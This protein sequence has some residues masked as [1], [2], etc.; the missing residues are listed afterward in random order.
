MKRI[1]RIALIVF[2]AGLLAGVAAMWL[3]E[4]PYK[5]SPGDTFV[6][7]EHGSS[8]AAIASTL[9]T[10][11]VIQYEWQVWGARLLNPSAKLQAGEYRFAEPVSALTVFDRI[12]R[13]DIYYFEFTVPEGSNRFDIAR[14]IAN[15]GT[16][17][18]EDFLKASADPAAIRDL[19]PHA[20]SLEGFLF[21]STYRLSHS[22]TAADLCHMMTAEFRRQWKKLDPARSA[23]VLKTVA[24]ASLVEKETGVAEE[25]KIVAGV[26]VN[27]ID[28]D[29]RLDCDP[30]TIYAALLDNRYTGVIHKSDLLNQNPYNTYQNVGL[31]P[32]PIANPGAASL[33]AALHPA[34]TDYL[35]FVAR[36]D[37]PGHVFSATRAAHEKAV[38]AYRHARHKAG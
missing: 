29:M 27:R 26:F 37:G 34:A 33:E 38:M 31:P 16:I 7:I 3:L 5:A 35:F 9:K 19:A 30:T 32:G 22:T 12:R 2:A 15:N 11:G 10:A 23:D 25:R 4:R 18:A 24:L 28:K 8:S 36:A 1:L 21:P 13:G 20:P 6:R 17:A 14:L